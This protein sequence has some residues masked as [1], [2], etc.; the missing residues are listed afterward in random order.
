MIHRVAIIG[1]MGATITL[2]TG[3]AELSEQKP[4]KI[5]I[6]FSSVVNGIHNNAYLIAAVSNLILWGSLLSNTASEYVESYDILKQQLLVVNNRTDFDDYSMKNTIQFS[7][8]QL[9]RKL[10]IACCAHLVYVSFWTL[11]EGAFIKHMTKECD[12]NQ[13]SNKT[14]IF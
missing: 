13:G 10:V 14:V 5:E 7:Q 3:A 11:V 8:Q 9:N 1:F 6:T 12:V 4:K 2:S